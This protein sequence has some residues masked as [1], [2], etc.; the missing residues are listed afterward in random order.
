M[1]LSLAHKYVATQKHATNEL[2]IQTIFWDVI[3]TAQTDYHCSDSS[4]Y[5]C[6]V[7]LLKQRVQVG[8]DSWS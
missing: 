5:K 8:H 1:H 3:F 2:V 4:R 7:S 6:C